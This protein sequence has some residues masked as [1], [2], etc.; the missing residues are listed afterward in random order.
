MKVGFV[1]NYEYRKKLTERFT[2]CIITG[3]YWVSGGF[4]RFKGSR[5]SKVH[6]FKGSRV[7]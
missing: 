2:I 1:L 5:S 6:E 7:Q 3:Q 4:G